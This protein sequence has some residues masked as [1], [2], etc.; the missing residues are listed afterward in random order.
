VTF[1]IFIIPVHQEDLQKLELGI[2]DSIFESIPWVNRIPTV[3]DLSGH[4]QSQC[5]QCVPLPAGNK[6]GANCAAL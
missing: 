2:M 4:L 3:F 1:P 5:Q 6:A